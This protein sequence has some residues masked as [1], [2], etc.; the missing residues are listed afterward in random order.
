MKNGAIV[1]NMGHSNT[2]IDVVGK[3]EYA[4]S[5]GFRHLVHKATISSDWTPKQFVVGVTNW[6]FSRR[7]FPTFWIFYILGK[8][9]DEWFNVGESA[10]PGR[11]RDLARREKGC[12]ACW[13]SS[14]QP[15]LFN[16]SILCS[17]HNSLHT[18][19]RFYQSFARNWSQIVFL[20]EH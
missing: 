4:S 3:P 12:S 18:G 6:T 17:I 16:S 7:S 1:C 8:S 2:E 5:N 20:L 13:R 14:A 11:S 10:F 15:Q 9:K 19:G